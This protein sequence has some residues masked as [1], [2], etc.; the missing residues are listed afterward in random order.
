MSRFRWLA[1][2]LAIA[3]LSALA[4]PSAAS[5]DIIRDNQWHLNYLNIADVHSITHGER[6]TVAVVDTGVDADHPDL[7]GAVVPGSDIVEPGGDGRKDLNGHGTAMAGI[8]AGRGRTDGA[9]ILGIAPRAIILPVRDDRIATLGSPRDAAA[10]IDWATM[11]RTAVICVAAGGSRDAA[12]EAAVRKAI[13]ADI[14]VVAGAG[15][16]PD[17]KQV[18]YPAAIPGVIAAAAVDQN[19]NH[20]SVSVTGPEVILAAPGVDIPSTYSFNQYTKGTGTSSATAIIAGAAA[21]VRSK[22]PNLSAP[23]VIHR[24]TATATDKGTPGRDPEYGYGVLDLVKALTADVPPPTPTA[25]SPRPKNDGGGPDD[26]RPVGFIVAGSI[27]CA[28]LVLA[29]GVLLVVRARR[30]SA[31]T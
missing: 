2:L 9:G 23:E 21:L 17:A 7:S 26:G 6:V 31:R 4:P 29:G 27:G 10:A 5:A 19:G 28:L 16:T 25:T 1:A 11:N 12:L 3:I 24:L 20:A 30:L 15:N 18:A 8:I 22:Y 14:V 13:D